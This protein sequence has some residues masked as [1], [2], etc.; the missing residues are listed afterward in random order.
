MNVWY[1]LTYAKMTCILV[2]GTDKD[3]LNLSKYVKLFL[4]LNYC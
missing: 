1:I 3:S 4:A 2:K